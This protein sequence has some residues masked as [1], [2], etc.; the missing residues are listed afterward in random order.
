MKKQQPFMPFFVG[1]F[2]VATAE[3]KCDESGLYV[4]LLAYQWSLGSLPANLDDLCMLVRCP[5]DRF[6]QL[7]PRVSAK[8]VQ[9]GDRLLNER[10][11]QHRAKTHA[12]SKKNALSGKKGGETKQRNRSGAVS[13]MVANANLSAISSATKALAELRSEKVANAT[14]SLPGPQAIRSSENVAIQS[15]PTH[16]NLRVLARGE[17]LG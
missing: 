8:F 14:E 3:W 17:N 6:D 15:N 11:E 2:M 7:W 5:R 13:E 9:C 12:L 4:I 10:L 16:P 1:D